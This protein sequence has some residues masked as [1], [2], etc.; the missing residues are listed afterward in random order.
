MECD[1]ISALQAV[2][3]VEREASFLYLVAIH[4][5]YFLRRQYY[6]FAGREGGTLATRLLG[7]T[8]R[9]RHVRVIECGRGWHIYHLTSKSVYEALNRPDSQHR[10]IKG[11]AYIKSRLM[12]LDFVLAHLNTHVLDNEG[13]K[14]EFFTGECGVDEDAM[15]RSYIGRLTYF[16]DGFPILISSTGIP[17]F[18]FFD[19][20]QVTSTRFERFLRQY[21]PLFTELGEFELTYVADNE[22][23]SARAKAVFRRFLPEDRIHGVTPMTPLGVDHFLKYLATREQLE[24]KGARIL[25][26]DMKVVDVG[27][28]IYTSLEHRA[29]YSAWMMG[30]ITEDKIRRRFLQA[31]L[32]VSFS[33]E[34][35]PYRYPVDGFHR[36]ALS[37]ESD[38]TPSQ[39]QV[40]TP[41]VEGNS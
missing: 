18:L 28:S 7:K 24:T 35:L 2:G 27:D 15:P 11:D 39:T 5:G 8:L 34:V 23:N 30:S 14:V 26:T 36:G 22:S 13:A 25:S 40:G 33:T 38:K 16:P 6:S 4:S 10:R 37:Y 19:E 41:A 20:G 12:V 17:R 9:R 21:Q 32:R 3:Y 1:P 29:L 31:S